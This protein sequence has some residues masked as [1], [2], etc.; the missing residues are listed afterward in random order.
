MQKISTTPNAELMTQARESLRGK[1]GL[2][3]GGFLTVMLISCVQFI[4]EIG[5]LIVLVITGPLSIGFAAFSLAISRGERADIA[6]IFSGFEKFGV[7]VGA[8]ILMMIFILLWMLLLIIPGIIAALSY[9]MTYYIIADENLEDPLEALK[10][11]KEM[12]DGNKWK[13]ACMSGRFIG[14]ML[15]CILTL[16]IGYIWLAPYMTISYIKFYEDIKNSGSAGADTP[17]LVHQFNA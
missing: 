12:M 1:W 7:G 16:G 15:L 6:Q 8:Y 11:S 17:A 4:P 10:K 5:P 14:W 9:S 13:L 3:I 2:A